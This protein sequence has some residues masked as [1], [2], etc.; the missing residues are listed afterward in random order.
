MAVDAVA[1]ESTY[2]QDCALG[3]IT[4]PGIGSDASDRV[5]KSAVRNGPMRGLSVAENSD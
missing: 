1:P 5:Q 2:R 3:P 4:G